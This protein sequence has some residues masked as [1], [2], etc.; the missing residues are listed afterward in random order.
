MGLRWTEEELALHE[1]KKNGARKSRTA[2]RPEAGIVEAICGWLELAGLPW[3]LTDASRVWGPEGEVRASK[4]REGWPDITAVGPDGRLVAI[5]CKSERGKL[6]PEQIA[7]L[8]NL[9]IHNAIVV[10]ARSLGD[11]VDY[12][13]LRYDH[14]RDDDDAYGLWRAIRA[15]RRGVG[16]R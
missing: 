4:V 14:L 8:T 5:E 2:A 10:E 1:R 6:S 7:T 3:T 13:A 11:V 16:A 15:Y 9:M 12:L